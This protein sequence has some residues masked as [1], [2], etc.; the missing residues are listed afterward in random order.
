MKMR[1]WFITVDMDTCFGFL[2]HS[3]WRQQNKHSRGEKFLLWFSSFVFS[4]QTILED[5]NILVKKQ[6][7]T[8][9]LHIH[10]QASAQKFFDDKLDTNFH[11]FVHVMLVEH[12]SR[13][14][15]SWKLLWKFNYFLN[16]S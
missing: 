6:N 4:D 16:P 15:D 9:S 3:I 8:E 5:F 14:I 1:V 2:A 13:V 7:S 10:S 12:Q 11:S